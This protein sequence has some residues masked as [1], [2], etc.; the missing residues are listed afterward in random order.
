MINTSTV[1]YRLRPINCNIR[2]Y[3]LNRIKKIKAFRKIKN[4]NHG[5]AVMYKCTQAVS[6]DDYFFCFSCEIIKYNCNYCKLI[7]YI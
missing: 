4:N 3:I 7:K 5:T 1:L 2:E 6:N